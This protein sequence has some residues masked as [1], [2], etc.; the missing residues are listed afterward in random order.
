M[1]TSVWAVK[2][3][4][5][6]RAVKTEGNV[7]P[8]HCWDLSRVLCDLAASCPL[9]VFHLYSRENGDLHPR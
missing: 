3:C 1:V 4:H 5:I 7:R 6:E 9:L 8:R 2:Q